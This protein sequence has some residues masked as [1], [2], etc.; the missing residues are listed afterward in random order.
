MSKTK[1]KINYSAIGA[2]LKSGDVTRVCIQAAEEH[3]ARAPHTH[4]D[5][6]VLNTRGR[7]GIVQ[8]MTKDDMDN[9]TLRKA[10]G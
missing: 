5:T 4:V 6:A 9:E 7:A 10:M 8:E 2:M 1:V 3:A